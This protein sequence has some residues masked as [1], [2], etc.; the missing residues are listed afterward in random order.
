MELES[1]TPKMRT[2]IV[3]TIILIS[4]GGQNWIYADILI[5]LYP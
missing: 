1:C 3:H 4:F 2:H 5:I